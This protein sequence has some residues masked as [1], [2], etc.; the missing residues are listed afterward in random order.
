MQI[1]QKRK[2]NKLSIKNQQIPNQF[3]V[4]K[5]V[6]TGSP[7]VK[8]GQIFTLKINALGPKKMGLVELN[9]GLTVLVPNTKLGDLVKVKLE[10]ILATK[11]NQTP[12]IMILGTLVQLIQKSSKSA[13][14]L[15]VGQIVPVIIK[16]K[17]L[18]IQV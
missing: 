18:K 7:K 16:K 4:K 13:Q 17:D 6:N 9:N 11:N 1:N 12:K 3:I 2:V 15:E 14:N 10:K 5:I 8:L